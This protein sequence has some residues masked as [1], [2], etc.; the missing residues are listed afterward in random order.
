MD[1]VVFVFE[2][3][4]GVEVDIEGFYTFMFLS[5]SW[6]DPFFRFASITDSIRFP[7]LFVS[8]RLFSEPKKKD[9]NIVCESVEICSRIRKK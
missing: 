6:T 7:S 5:N 3:E 2:L 9:L 8:G 4:V 1:F